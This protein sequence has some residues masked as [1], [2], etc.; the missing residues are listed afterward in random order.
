MVGLIA[1]AARF[2]L[3]AVYG[4]ESFMILKRE[5]RIIGVIVVFHVEQSVI[6]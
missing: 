4:L 2:D 3:P 5:I 1:D 6:L